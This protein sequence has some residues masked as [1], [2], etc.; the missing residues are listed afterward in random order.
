MGTSTVH[1][2][3]PAAEGAAR[4][5]LSELPPAQTALDGSWWPRSRELADEVPA[6]VAELRRQGRPADRVT[7]NPQL[8]APGPSRLRADGHLLRLGWFASE[9]P[10]QI[11]LTEAG[12]R[13]RTVLLVV[14]PQTPEDVAER[15]SAEVS[16]TASWRT[17]TEVLE[18]SGA[19]PIG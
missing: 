16:D 17:P 2:G 9:D 18:A 19:L 14:P 13:F 15:V 6:L 10:H 5:T 7:Y 3:H 12:S 1:E 11:T 8:W 4:L